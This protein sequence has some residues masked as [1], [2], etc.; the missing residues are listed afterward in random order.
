MKKGILLLILLGFFNNSEALPR[1]AQ[2]ERCP[3]VSVIQSRG[4]SQ[5]LARDS[6]GKWYAGRT[7]EAYNTDQLWTFVIGDIFAS[8]Q[9]DA[10]AE[11]YEALQS[12]VSMGDPVAAPSG[13]WLCLYKNAE[14]LP[15]GAIYPPINEPPFIKITY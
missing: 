4:L 10:L 6:N 5:N 13:K 9:V 12:L 15:S 8:S 11:A 7:A 2:P 14:G 1:P 3:D